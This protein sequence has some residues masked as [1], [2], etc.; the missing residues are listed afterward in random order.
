[1]S[2]TIDIKPLTLA[3]DDGSTFEAQVS[4]IYDRLERDFEIYPGVVLPKGGE[5]SF[6]RV[7][8]AGATA[9][10]RMFSVGEVVFLNVDDQESGFHTIEYSLKTDSTSLGVSCF[11]GLSDDLTT[12]HTE[13]TEKTP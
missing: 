9:N 7:Q 6:T 11:V 5:Y 3:F 1:V 8:I 2:R 10:Q 12:E 4:P 13:N